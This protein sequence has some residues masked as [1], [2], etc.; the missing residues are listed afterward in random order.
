MHSFKGKSVP[1]SNK[2]PYKDKLAARN[3]QSLD[4]EHCFTEQHPNQASFV[5]AVVAVVAVVAV[6]PSGTEGAKHCC[7]DMKLLA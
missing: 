6:L 7:A 5:E 3:K 2:Q 1:S 4:K